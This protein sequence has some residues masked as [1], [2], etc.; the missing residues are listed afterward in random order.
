MVDIFEYME[1]VYEERLAICKSCPLYKDIAGRAICNPNRY[2]NTKDLVTV[3]DIPRI[4]Y[5][6]G[7]GCLLGK[8]KLANPNSKCTVGKW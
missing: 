4:G 1:N 7:C 3:S 8:A 6:R 5:K 2:L